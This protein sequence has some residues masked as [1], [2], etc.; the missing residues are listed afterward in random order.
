MDS[1]GQRSTFRQTPIRY[2]DA[3]VTSGHNPIQ[4]RLW[5]LTSV[6]YTSDGSCFANREPVQRKVLENSH[7]T[8]DK[9]FLR[10]APPGYA[11]DGTL[12]RTAALIL[13]LAAVLLFAP[14]ARADVDDATHPYRIAVDPTSAGTSIGTADD[15]GDD[16]DEDEGPDDDEGSDDD[17]EDDEDD[18]DEGSD[19][20]ED[21]DDGSNNPPAEQNPPQGPAASAA[22]GASGLW[23]GLLIVFLA[24]IA[25][26]TVVVLRRR[27]TQNR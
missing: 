6:G 7:N 22:P 10:P 15:D 21:D 1:R 18:E 9:T 4:G 20:D 27:M 19:D 16:D 8:G 25:A 2:I 3:A 12:K 24:G 13:A 26:G 11:E 14:V 23:L 5:C 17:D